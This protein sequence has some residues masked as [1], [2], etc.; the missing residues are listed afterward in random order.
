MQKKL[1]YFG[2]LLGL[3]NQGVRAAEDC[4]S[5]N[6]SISPS[7]FIER[8]SRAMIKTDFDA[9]RMSIRCINEIYSEERKILG[10]PF[11][12]GW[13]ALDLIRKYQLPGHEVAQKTSKEHPYNLN[14]SD[15]HLRR[16]IDYLV[17]ERTMPL[18]RSKREES[19][20]SAFTGLIAACMPQYTEAAK[21]S[22]L[23]TLREEIVREYQAYRTA[24]P[25]SS[26]Y[27]K[28]DD[29]EPLLPSQ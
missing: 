25:T 27:K 8:Y 11:T 2:F 3:L 4:Y 15:D 19:T 9:C 13:I 17:T 18:F 23:E 22:Q 6:S 1:I 21:K 7:Y 20:W 16:T 10:T 14:I 12:W 29:F 26:K 24:A 5:H 28:D